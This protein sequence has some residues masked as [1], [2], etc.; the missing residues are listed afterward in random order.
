MDLEAARFDRVLDL[1]WRRA[2]YSSI[3]ADA[4]YQAAGGEGVGSEPENPGLDDEPPAPAP[5][6]RRPGCREPRGMTWRRTG[7][8]PREPPGRHPGRPG[9]GHAGAR[10]AGGGRLRGS[11]AGRRLSAAIQAAGVRGGVG[12]GDHA[13]LA[14]GL[15]AALTTP[16]GPLLPGACLGDIARR[17]RLDE[18]GFELPLAGG[19]V[20]NGQV[21]TADIA[22]LLARH[23]PAGG[24]LAGYPERLLDPL[25]ATTLRGYLTGSLDLVF[26]R[27]SG[28]GPPTV[29]RRGLQ[30]QLA[31]RG[32]PA[33]HA[34]H[35][36]RG[37]A[38]RRDA[39]PSLSPPGPAV[40]GRP[41]PLPALAA[42]GLFAGHPPGRGAVSVPA[43][44]DRARDASRSTV[45]RAGSSPG[46]RPPNS[47]SACLTFS[48]QG[49]RW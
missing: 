22:A 21:S 17:D 44:H 38:G 41:A 4:H 49:P 1:R 5:A 2:S 15:A 29:V 47:S 30:D 36:R 12:A 28:A 27:S 35:Y 48:S 23:L 18:L 3:T 39:T 43:R 19:D 6:G 16:L 24:P 33:A 9:S 46:L 37:G 31:G 14:D 40:P 20:P 13:R 26:R 45:G 42:T 32:R 10:R 34:W 25:L 8:I 7:R 11:R